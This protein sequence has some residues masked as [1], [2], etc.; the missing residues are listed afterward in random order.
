[1]AATGA[2]AKRIGHVGNSSNALAH[3]CSWQLSMGAYSIQRLSDATIAESRPK[4]MTTET[5]ASR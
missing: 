5:T 1:M 4:S 2:G 3:W